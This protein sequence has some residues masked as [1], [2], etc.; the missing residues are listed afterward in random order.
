MTSGTIFANHKLPIQTYL[1]AIALFVNAV[2][3][4][5]A[6]QMAR[7]LNIEYKSAY[8]LLHKIRKALLEQ[9]E[10]TTFSGEVDIDGTYIHPAPR[11][12]N[13]KIDRIDYRLKE[14]QNPEKRCILVAREH[15]T[16]EEKAKNPL[17]RGAKSTQVVVTF[18][19]TQ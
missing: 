2:K 19:E 6:L 10:F 8:V 9:R 12:A 18:G 16:A 14:N 4:I 3:G 15:Y 11:K 5:S 17:Y 7:D 1:Y 13:K